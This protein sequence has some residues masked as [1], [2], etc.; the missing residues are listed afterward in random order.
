MSWQDI[1]AIGLALAA[2][3]YVFR[4]IRRTMSGRG[5][6]GCGSE[7]GTCSSAKSKQSTGIKVTPLV[8]LDIGKSE[9][10]QRRSKP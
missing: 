2:G 9:P 10:D 3:A 1:I 4:R 7:S 8:K 5:G 6:C